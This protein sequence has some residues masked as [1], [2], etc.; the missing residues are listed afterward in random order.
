MKKGMSLIEALVLVLIL[1]VILQV[2][3]VSFQRME[4]GYRLQAGVWEVLAKMN[5]AR[6]KA[7]LDGVPVR[8]R[9]SPGA[10]ALDE[11]DETREEWR[12]GEASLVP[13]IVLGANGAPIF[14]PEGTISPLASITVANTRGAYK[15]TLAITGRTKVTRL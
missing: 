14:Q 12:P 15:I 11:W 4:P 7:M 1:A 6:F 9:F 5:Q 10:C 13:G 2:G 8:V 3:A